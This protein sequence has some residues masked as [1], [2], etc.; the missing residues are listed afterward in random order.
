MKITTKINLITTAWILCVLIAVNAV[1]FFSFMKITVNMEEDILI[2]KAQNVIAEIQMDDTPHELE[3]KLTTFLTNHSFIR[4]IQPDS[5]IRS[6]V[7]N[8]H[9]L[10]KKFKGEFS[11]EQEAHRSTI[12]QG[13]KEEQILIVRV[14]IQSNGK[15]VGTLEIGDRLLGLELGKDVLLSILTFCTLL[16]AGL[17]LL[18]GRW[19]SSV[20]MR[21][22]SN[23]INTME[24]IEQSGIP[25]KIIIHEET[26]DELQKMAVTFNRM[27]SRLD[28]NLD[29]QKQFIS[30]ASHEIRTPLTIIKSYADLLRRRRIKSEEEALDVINVIHSE[31]TRIQKMTE[32]LLELADTEM[33][34]TLDSKS[35]NIITLCEN[36]FK[37]FKEVYG[38]EINF[39]Y[40]EDTIMITAD[41]LKI[42]QV[43]IILLDNA[44]KYSTDKIDVY[45][46]DHSYSTVIRV[47]DYGMGIPEHEMEHIFER[48]YRVDKAR[49]RETGGT[50]LGLS[51]AKNIMNQHN[52]EIKVAN[53]DGIGTEMVLS[54]PKR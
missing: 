39:H 47:K 5:K 35:V 8:D 19:L 46:E 10:I 38:R 7:S 3:K 32:R 53:I 44:I 49:S 29:K 26:K 51:I 23:M 18:G 40:Q 54:F 13:H 48:F 24:D 6:E 9:Y 28:V 20:I 11:T 4:I 16:G 42:K 12:K 50:G 33:E 14:P 25:K 2:H 37:P 22:I 27:M 36:V 45:V 30:D 52:G 34:N 31:A 21:P 1:V 41:E 15:V 17:S 43:I